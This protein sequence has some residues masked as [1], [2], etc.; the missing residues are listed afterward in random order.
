MAILTCQQ[1]TK[2]LVLYGYC[3]KLTDEHSTAVIALVPLHTS[4]SIAVI[5]LHHNPHIT[6]LKS[7][8][9]GSKPFFAHCSI[10]SNDK[11]TLQLYDTCGHGDHCKTVLIVERHTLYN[12]KIQTCKD[13][14]VPPVSPHT[15][16]T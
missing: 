1:I 4:D 8:R 12:S 16:Q 14:E 2:Q 15:A 10:L 9:K 11:N 6:I 13:Q 7:C 3:T 5:A